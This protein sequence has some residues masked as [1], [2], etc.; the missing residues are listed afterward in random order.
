LVTDYLILAASHLYVLL[1]S[2]KPLDG[3][4]YSVKIF[5]SEYGKKRLE[6]EAMIGPILFGS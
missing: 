6:K 4:I 1:N 2:F 5:V 3:A